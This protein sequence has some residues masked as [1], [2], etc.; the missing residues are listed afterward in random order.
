MK[1]RCSACGHDLA[2][3]EGFRVSAVDIRIDDSTPEGKRASE[4]FGGK[5]FHICY[6]CWLKSLGVK[7]HGRVIQQT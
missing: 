3:K 2:D 4:L 1:H 5:E 7:Q 6:V